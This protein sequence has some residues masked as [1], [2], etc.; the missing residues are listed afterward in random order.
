MHGKTGRCTKCYGNGE[1]IYYTNHHIL[2]KFLSTQDQGRVPSCG[3][4]ALSV[5]HNLTAFCHNDAS[6]E[7]KDYLYP[8]YTVLL[9]EGC[10]SCILCSCSKSSLILEYSPARQSF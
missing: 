5:H 2:G 7:Q 1:Q 8:S 6:L 3:T 9:C 4:Q 10:A